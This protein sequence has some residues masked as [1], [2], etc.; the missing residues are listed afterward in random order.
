MR[1]PKTHITLTCCSILTALA[2]FAAGAP[3][4]MA[5]DTI[6]PDIPIGRI[7]G[8]TMMRDEFRAL[9]YSQL[10]AIALNAHAYWVVKGEYPVGYPQL[11]GSDACVIDAKNMFTDRP[12]QSIYF[13]PK[14]T[15]MTSDP[16]LEIYEAFAASGAAIGGGPS[17]SA[18]MEDFVGKLPDAMS[19]ALKSQPAMRMLRVKPSA[20][21]D[22]TPGDVFYY[23]KNGLLQLV[24]FAPDGT[25]VEHVNEVPSQ[26]WLE[27]I[28][29]GDSSD[30]WPYSVYAAS[31]LYFTEMLLPQYYGMVQ[32]MGDHATLAQAQYSKLGAQER[33]T[34]ASELHLELRNPLTREPA[35]VSLEAVPGAFVALAQGAALPLRLWMPDGKTIGQDD[36][37]SSIVAAPQAGSAGKKPAVKPPK[38]KRPGAPPMG[39][40]R[41]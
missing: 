40:R 35:T 10:S 12:V 21:T 41:E 9:A 30:Y 2:L 26:G 8:T 6:G 25:F 33:I 5:Q 31:V 38:P 34:M 3:P 4:A 24:M 28:R 37:R 14:A 17:P 20:I 16:S 13:E 7:P 29:L 19:E 1:Q 18:T 36:L 11:R 32:F 23:T 27:R 39:G 15:D 22:K